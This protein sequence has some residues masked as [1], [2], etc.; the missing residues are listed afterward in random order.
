MFLGGL[1]PRV[2]I[3]HRYVGRE[4][5]VVAL[6]T[7]TLLTSLM[8]LCGVLKPLRQHG[9]TGP[10]ILEIMVLLFPFFLVFTVPFA[11]MV[12]CCWVYG[13][14]SSD[15][16]LSA[17]SSSGINVQ[18]LLIVPLAIGLLAMVMNIFL[19]NWL[20]PNWALHR[21]EV[22]L[23]RHGK[24]IFYREL[25]RRGSF[26]LKPS[27]I[28][29]RCII[30]ADGINR[31]NDVLYGIAVA[32]YAKNSLEVEQMIT[33]QEADLR[34]YS[35]GKNG[36][37]LDSVA[38]VPI[39]ATVVAL[40]EYSYSKA[41]SLVF[42]GKIRQQIRQKLSALSLS[43]LMAMGREP[44]RHN[45]IRDLA[46]EA[47]R[48]FIDGEMVKTL[49]AERAKVGYFELLGPDRRYRFVGR[50]LQPVFS[51]EGAR[52]ILENATIEEYLLDGR[53][54]VRIFAD[55]SL[56]DLKLVESFADTA[57]SQK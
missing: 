13:R 18:S 33:A 24:D 7:A 55:V 54:P 20:V 36:D 14:L 43:D 39:Q 49:Q 2:P 35:S 23:A 10:E 17:C 11:L 5:M 57:D 34:F 53:E 26:T 21:F 16:E 29:R 45:S 6:L 41:A 56:V 8:A 44:E 3:L 1:W 4:L 22:L 47:R 50:P 51:E 48:M 37:M 30:H 12:A 19:A 40:P 46:Q 31:E 28:G 32:V 25:D 15:N 27:Q 38:I 42:T 9:I 52:N